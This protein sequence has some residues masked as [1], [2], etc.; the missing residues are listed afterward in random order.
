[1][2]TNKR[3]NVI[4]KLFYTKRSLAA[5]I[6]QLGEVI[7]EG[8]GG[9]GDDG[10]GGGFMAADCVARDGE[11]QKRETRGYSQLNHGRTIVVS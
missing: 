10:D 1:M 9:G 2:C 11:A 8:G 3:K 7:N 6:V 5:A 4:K